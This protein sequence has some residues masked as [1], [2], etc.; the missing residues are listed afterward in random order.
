MK[1]IFSISLFAAITMLSCK[2]ELQPQDS[3]PTPETAS[4]AANNTEASAAAPAPTQQ[5]SQ[6]SAQQTIPNQAMP[7]APVKV[8]P[9]MNPPHGQ[10]GHRCDIAPGAP[11]SSAPAKPAANNVTMAPQKSMPTSAAPALLNP[12]PAPAPTAPGMNPPHGQ[13]GHKCDV[14]VGAPLPKV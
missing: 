12:A 7:Q 1:K 5:I 8:A 4:T 14:T 10:P 6:P 13:P 9:G 2:Q 11:L 3:I